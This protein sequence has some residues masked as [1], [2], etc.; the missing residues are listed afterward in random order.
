MNRVQAFFAELKRRKV[1]R[2]GIA[3]F[4]LAWVLMQVADVTFERLGLP[5]WTITLVIVLS[6]AG[7]PVALLLAWAYELTPGGLEREVT[8][9]PQPEVAPSPAPSAEPAI[10]V[11]PFSDL[12]P[13]GEQGYFC[14]G[15]AEEILSQL[16]RI[17]ELRV[18][19]RTASFQFRDA[20]ADIGE[21][22]RRLHVQAVLEGSVRK[23]GDK[24]RVTAKLVNASD[25][26]QLWSERFE[27]DLDDV[28]SVQDEIADGIVR[29]MQ[30]TLDPLTRKFMRTGRTSNLEAY[31]FYLRGWAHFHGFSSRSQRLARQMFKNSVEADPDFAKGWAGL[32]AA[33]TFNYIYSRSLEELKTE[34]L[35]ASRRAVELCPD[36]PETNAA[37]GMALLID[38]DIEGAERSFKRALQ[39]DADHYYS[40]LFYAR[41]C[42]HQGRFDDALGLMLR[43]A[44]IRPEDYE[45][46]AFIPQV[47]T[48]LDKDEAEIAPWREELV[49]RCEAQI[50]AYPD[51]VRA[52]YLLAAHLAGMD[53]HEQGEKLIRQAL[54]LA[55]D[56]GPL[57]YNSAC[58]YSLAGD[59]ERA[60]DLLERAMEQG[61]AGLSW[62]EHDSDFD[63][64]RGEPRF[65]ALLQKLAQF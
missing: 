61:A 45:P 42:I 5:S 64:L 11:L 53:R 39:L 6:I 14:D 4:A 28:F 47:M 46:V 21:I 12:S 55:P 48:S 27:G 26:Y 51:D 33:N 54:E 32:A 30:L 9:D 56:D 8:P 25:G 43:A 49:R 36:L 63:N 16:M 2:V 40:L 52:M 58:F 50:A 19:S 34:A 41:A 17:S 23:A 24:L 29:A 31:D 10:A 18:A 62:V 57:L 59:T 13:D 38:E 3:Y 7:F 15:L 44:E 1:I 37:R 22:A 35:D 65:E 60:L 20:E